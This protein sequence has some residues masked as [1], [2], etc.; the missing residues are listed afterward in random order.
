MSHAFQVAADL[1]DP[2]PEPFADDWEGFLEQR[3]KTHLWTRQRDIIRSV[4]DHQRTAVPACFSSSKSFSAAR[5]ACAWM[6]LHPPGTAKVIT[7]ATV[8]RQVRTILWPEIR[9]AHSVG[10]LRGRVNQTEWHL[11]V[12]GSEN[13]YGQGVSSADAAGFHG[14]HAEY[15]LVI[16]DEAD[17][18]PREIWDAAEGL[19]TTPED[20]LVAIGNP[21]DPAGP[22][23]D[24]CKPGS[25]FNV[26]R[27]SAFDAPAFTGEQVPEKLH[28]LLVS[29]EWVEDKQHRWGEADPRYISK[30]LAH[31]PEDA[32]GSLVHLIWME[33]AQKRVVDPSLPIELGVD[34]AGPNAG[35]ESVIALRKGN[36]AR[37]FWS[38]R[39]SDT[40][41][42]AGMVVKTA[43][44]EA[45]TS[46][47]IDYSGIGQGVYDAVR[48]SIGNR[49]NVVPVTF[50]SAPSDRQHFVYLV[51]E[52]AWGLRQRLEDGDID[53]DEADDDLAQQLIS[54]RF[55][56]NLKG[57]TR[58][59]EK[60]AMK[61]RG[62]PSPD[63]FDALLLAFWSVAPA[64][65]SS[66]VGRK[67]GRVTR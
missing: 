60:K 2:P 26:I 34:V 23:A 33:E 44:D 16:I 7:T 64:A 37:T 67:I 32:E 40:Q 10:K 6:Q 21:W 66:P 52:M 61:A 14:S 43:L 46:I 36:W 11:D 9:L 8:F 38:S 53:I 49:C 31:F 13:I 59:E 30:V 20:R 55:S 29:K 5:I 22:F 62:L 57:Q 50:G 42:I 45:A 24:A 41:E 35:D 54:R 65:I 51:D 19:I 48:R 12:G 56:I 3:L 47:K 63:R 58:L 18:V 1:L 17:G 4:H 15:V 27:I 39:S 28:R 25:G